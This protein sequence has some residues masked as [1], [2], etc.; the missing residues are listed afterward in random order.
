MGQSPHAVLNDHHGTID[1]DTEVERTETHQV[2]AD[3]VA[4]H[5]REGEQHRQR[6]HHRGDQRGTDVA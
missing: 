1:D 3:L 6:D 5:A 2:R 4:D